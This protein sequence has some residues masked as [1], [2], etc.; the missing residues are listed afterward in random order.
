MQA[1]AFTQD[2]HTNDDVTLAFFAKQGGNRAGNGAD[3]AIHNRT[4]RA[5]ALNAVQSGK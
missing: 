1:H 2:R 4:S 3:K 5:N